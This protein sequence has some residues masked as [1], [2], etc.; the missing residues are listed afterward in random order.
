MLVYL[1]ARYSRYPEM[2]KYAAM[3]AQAGHEVTGRWILGDHELRSDGQS[4]ADEWAVRWAQEDWD[5]LMAA[6]AVVSF[7]EGPGEVPGRAR[8]G[9]HVEFGAAR[10]AGK[11]LFV[12]GHRENVFHYMPDVHFIPIGPD[13]LAALVARLDDLDDLSKAPEDRREHPWARVGRE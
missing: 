2:Q 5:D 4:D 8:G 3:L 7:T 6:E 9:R 13:P 10:A 1:A 12:V 11:L